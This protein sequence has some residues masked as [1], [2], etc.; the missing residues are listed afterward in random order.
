MLAVTV[1]RPGGP[2]RLSLQKVPEPVP[3]DGEVLIR[4]CAAGVN[5]ADLLQREGNYPAP[6]GVP[7]W[8]GLECSGTIEAIGGGVEDLSAGDR[9]CAL[10]AGG[11]YGELAVARSGQ[12]LSVSPDLDLESAAGLPEALATV[13]SNLF[14]IAGLQSGETVLIHGGASG[15][16]TIAIQMA[17]AFGA[18]VAVTAGDRQK[19]DLCAS[20]GAEVLINYR[21]ADFVEEL[22]AATK[23]LGA[24]VILDPVGGAYLDR[25]IRSL[26]RGGRIVLIANQS[27]EVG[28]LRVGRLMSKWGSIHASALRSRPESEKDQILSEVLENV[29]PLVL[30]GQIKPVIDSRF[31][32]ADAR[33]AHERMES[34]VHAGKILL[35]P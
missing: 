35:I 10:L 19:L 22:R 9:V 7:D 11:G 14:M 23:D 21:Q 13:W 15:I 27:G 32:F 2:E 8:P 31:S 3:G 33:L 17:K 28:E 25:N 24:D 12:V 18:K 29:W 1:S 20:L 5:R 34:G 6:A 26:A 30:S 16:G 4:V